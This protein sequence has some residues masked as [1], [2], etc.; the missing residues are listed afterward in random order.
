MRIDIKENKQNDDL[1]TLRFQDITVG[2]ALAI[3]NAMRE[4]KKVSSGGDEV[5]KVLE[6]KLPP[7]LDVPW[8]Y[9]QAIPID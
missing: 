8:T 7:K 3:I 2:Q 5:L 4:Y 1:V 6:E 9:E